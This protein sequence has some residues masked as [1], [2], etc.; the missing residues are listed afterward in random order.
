MV[1]GGVECCVF[2]RGDEEGDEDEDEDEEGEEEERCHMDQ[3]PCF[4][5]YSVRLSPIDI[6]T[7]RYSASIDIDPPQFAGPQQ[8]PAR[9]QQVKQHVKRHPQLPQLCPLNPDDYLSAVWLRSPA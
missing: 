2:K 3:C 6:H 7:W 4:L 1:G 5:F 8:F 9:P